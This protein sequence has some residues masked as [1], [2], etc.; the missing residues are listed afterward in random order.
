MA[1]NEWA[2]VALLDDCSS[3]ESNILTKATSGSFPSIVDTFYHI[4]DGQ[5][6]W[7]QRLTGKSMTT[8]PSAG[9]EKS[10]SDIY[11]NL[12]THSSMLSDWTT[13]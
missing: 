7:L 1:Y 13:S 2:N 9:T 8:F 10:W 4:L 6:I 3:L 12:K 5:M 11:G